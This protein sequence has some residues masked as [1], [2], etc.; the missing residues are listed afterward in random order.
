[1]A[2]LKLFSS[3]FVRGNDPHSSSLVPCTHTV[4]VCV[5]KGGEGLT[6]GKHGAH[7]VVLH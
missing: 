3:S 2:F 4:V 6:S 1:M 5:L 7:K